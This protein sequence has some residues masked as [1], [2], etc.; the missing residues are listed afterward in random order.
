MVIRMRE[1]MSQPWDKVIESIRKLCESEEK[2]TLLIAIDGKS[3]SGKTTLANCIREQLGG[4]VFHMDDFFLRPEQRTKERLEEVGGNVDYERFKEVLEQIG[5]KSTICYQAY[6]C[7][8]QELQKPI[9]MEAMRLNIVEGSYSMHPYFEDVY[10]LKIAVDMKEELQRE[11]I[12]QRNGAAMLKRFEEEWIPKENAYFE[13]YAIF[14]K[15]D[16]R[17]QIRE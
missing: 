4:N 6:D 17:I 16:V 12:L 13:K 10:D 1:T 14:E 15:C 8:L 2:Q 5:N 3:G 7:K 9:Q 11:R